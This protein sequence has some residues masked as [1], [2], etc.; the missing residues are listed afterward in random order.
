LIAYF[1]NHPLFTPPDFGRAQIAVG[2][3]L[4]AVGELGNFFCHM[5]FRNLRKPGSQMD[6]VAVSGHVM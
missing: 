5:V 6:S 3:S 2:L 4:F 1:V